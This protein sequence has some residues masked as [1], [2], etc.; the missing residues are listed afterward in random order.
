MLTN[1]P[2]CF[3]GN[4]QFQKVTCFS[5]FP[6]FSEVHCEISNETMTTIEPI[7]SVETT[8][9]TV[10]TAVPSTT[11]VPQT[12]PETVTTQTLPETVTT[13]TLPETVTTQTLPETVTTQT[14]SVSATTETP[15]AS[16][17]TAVPCQDTD[18]CEGHYTC[19]GEQRVCRTGYTG[20]D[21][22]KRDIDENS[23]DPQCPKGVQCKN[24]G[25]C[26]NNDCC[27]VAGYA[28]KY[29]E[30]EIDECLSNPCQNGA[31]CLDVLDRYIC[32]CL[33]GNGPAQY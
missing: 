19:N 1:S 11:A 12:L 4:L 8:S 28:G 17:T 9:V 14:V 32:R 29:C 23:S 24:G 16:S 7:T 30:T 20:E 21:C 22:K 5:W 31:T 18:S 10:T 2:W 15:A 13:Q 27:C 6:G 26:F 3:Y 33:P 25:T